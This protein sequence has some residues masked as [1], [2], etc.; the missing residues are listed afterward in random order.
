MQDVKRARTYQFGFAAYLADALDFYGQMPILAGEFGEQRGV[1]ENR[2]RQES[3]CFLAGGRVAVVPE[4]RGQGVREPA[5]DVGL[6]VAAGSPG[7]LAAGGFVTVAGLGLLQRAE[8]AQR[9]EFVGA[10]R[11]AGGFAQLGLAGGGRG[12]GGEFGLDDVVGAGVVE[13][14]RWCRGEQLVDAFPLRELRRAADVVGQV[15]VPGRLPRVEP[16]VLDG[17]RDGAGVHTLRPA[18]HHAAADAGG[19]DR[20]AG[21]GDARGEQ[22]AGIAAGRP[23]PGQ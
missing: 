7:E 22:A 3:G 4:V 20:L 16:G 18:P 21:R 11:D 12:V 19:V 14:A 6:D 2:W 9:L 10:G 17:G 1:G 23:V 15:L 13:G 8:L 5:V